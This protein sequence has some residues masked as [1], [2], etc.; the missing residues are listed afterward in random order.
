MASLLSTN[1]R[2]SSARKTFW[3]QKNLSI[4]L[5]GKATKIY[6]NDCEA[7]LNYKDIIIRFLELFLSQYETSWISW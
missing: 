1:M 4:E 3:R 7:I 6:A 5:M 2:V